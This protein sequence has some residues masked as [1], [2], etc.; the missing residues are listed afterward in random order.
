MRTAAMM[1]PMMIPIFAPLLSPPL[2]AVAL[3]DGVAAGG[4]VD[5]VDGEVVDDDDNEVSWAFAELMALAAA[6]AAPMKLLRGLVVIAAVCPAT[7]ATLANA[8]PAASRTCRCMLPVVDDDDV[9]W[10][11]KLRKQYHTIVGTFR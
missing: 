6:P 1:Q 3:W 9:G 7:L 11:K 2:A 8:K 5:V 4:G 10:R